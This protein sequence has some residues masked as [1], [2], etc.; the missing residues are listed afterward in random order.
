M[1]PRRERADSTVLEAISAD[2]AVIK[3]RLSALESQPHFNCPSP[4]LEQRV[5][6]LEQRTQRTEVALGRIEG[7]Q[8]ETNNKIDSNK[9]E[10]FEQIESVR[11][12][13]G[14]KVDALRK[15]T[16]A[17]IG[18]V[19]NAVNEKKQQSWT[20]AQTIFM[21]IIALLGGAVTGLGV[22]LIGHALVK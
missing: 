6:A 14:E 13:V 12:E 15:E 10:R 5:I 1:P 17:Q 3:Q 22:T 11:A 9:S 2:I 18:A 7:K 16:S 19:L 21:G 8:D 20:R 4:V